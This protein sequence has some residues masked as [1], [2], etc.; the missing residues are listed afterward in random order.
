MRG[1]EG[2]EGRKG[3]RGEGGKGGRG[4]ERK[5]GRGEGRKGGRREGVKCLHDGAGVTASLTMKCDLLSMAAPVGHVAE[6]LSMCV[7]RGVLL[8]MRDHSREG[9]RLTCGGM[10]VSLMVIVLHRRG[11]LL[12]VYHRRETREAAHNSAVFR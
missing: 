4:E 12:T 3:G 5:G 1:R 2:R 8:K 7:R 6:H 11:Y 9:G 10:T